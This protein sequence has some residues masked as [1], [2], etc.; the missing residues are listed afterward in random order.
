MPTEQEHWID[1]LRVIPTTFRKAL[2][3]SDDH[4]APFHGYHGDATQ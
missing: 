3:P 4:A 2:L 1:Q